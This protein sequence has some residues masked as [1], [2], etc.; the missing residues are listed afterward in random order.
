[1][2]KNELPIV[3]LSIVEAKQHH[4]KIKQFNNPTKKKYGI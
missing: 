4:K 2:A 1:L 3:T